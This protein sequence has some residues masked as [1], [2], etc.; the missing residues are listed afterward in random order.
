MG[1]D[2]LQLLR[3][4]ALSRGML[5]QLRATWRTSCAAVTAPSCPVLLPVV[6]TGAAQEPPNDAEAELGPEV[7]D[8]QRRDPEAL[9]ASAVAEALN[10]LAMQAA[11]VTKQRIAEVR[12]ELMQVIAQKDRELEALRDAFLRIPGSAPSCATGPSPSQ[13][14][15]PPVPSRRP[16]A[17]S[18]SC[19]SPCSAVA[20]PRSAV[21]AGRGASV[22]EQLP[23][24][25]RAH[26]EHMANDAD[27]KY[28]SEYTAYREGRT[29]SEPLRPRS[30][31]FLWVQSVI[32]G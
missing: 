3:P 10:E 22:W 26:W 27:L 4:P 31:Y 24:T 32:Q 2:I 12:E 29:P 16:G 23:H 20:C 5:L 1:R 18:R 11:A 9:P 7:V 17:T 15:P 30:A 8:D 13:A 25:E 21:L 28:R 19:S 6:E 14:T